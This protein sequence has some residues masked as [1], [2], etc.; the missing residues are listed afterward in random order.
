MENRKM[1]LSIIGQDKEIN[2]S[3][4]EDVDIYRIMEEIRGLLIGWGYHENSIIEGCE[5]IIEE[6]GNINGKKL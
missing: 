4:D 1:K 5:Y 2:I 3:I 6:Y